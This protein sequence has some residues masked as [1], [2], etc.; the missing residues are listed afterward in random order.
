VNNPIITSIL[1]IIGGVIYFIY[2]FSVG[3][4]LQEYL[5]QKIK[6]SHNFFLFNTFIWAVIYSS[7]TIISDG[8]GMNFSGLMAIPM[9]Y[10]FFAFLHFLAFPALTIKSIELNKKASFGEY[11]G[12]FF[13]ILFL[14]IG[15]WFLQPRIKQILDNKE[16]ID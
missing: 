2:P 16:I 9:L 6:L 3:H 15:I 4:C 12:D 13:L 11:I 10:V 5:P 8:R 14:P 7:I 1:S